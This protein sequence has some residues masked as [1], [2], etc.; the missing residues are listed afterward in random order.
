[1]AYVATLE[2]CGWAELNGIQYATAKDYNKILGVAS[3][4]SKGAFFFCTAHE[5][6]EVKATSAKFA[7]FLTKHE[8]GEVTKLPVFYNPNSGNYIFGYMWVVNRIAL[9]KYCNANNI[10]ATYKF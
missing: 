7:K 8:L 6:Q 1:M 9:R 3:L 5:D 4:Y 2:C 10:K